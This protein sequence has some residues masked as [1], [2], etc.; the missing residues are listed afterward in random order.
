[1]TKRSSWG[2][3]F[4]A[5]YTMI[6]SVM[7]LFAACEE[8]VDWDFKAAENG[9]LVVEAILT[10]ELKTQ[11]LKL[12]LSYVDW[13]GD[14]P[15][16]SGA[17]VRVQTDDELYLF[18]EDPESPGVYKSLVSFAAQFQKKYRLEITWAGALYEAEAEMVQVLPFSPFKFQ[19]IGNTNRLQI[20]NPPSL[21]SPHEQVMYEVLIDWQHLGGDGARQAKTYYYTF[22]T[23]DV[24]ELFRPEQARLTF[25]K[26]SIVTVRKHG[27]HPD[28]AAFCRALMFETAWQGGVFDQAS[29]V[30]PTNLSGGAMGFFGVCAV[31]QQVQLAQ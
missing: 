21:Y 9:A 13:N 14:T 15:P 1:M 23:V 30:L 22:N 27:L 6:L 20:S 17:Q 3:G 10:N 16:V 29:G 25:P 24:P 7:L 11:G 2:I 18:A 4:G 8:P 26:G 12:S 19:A 31:R 28:F 5:Y